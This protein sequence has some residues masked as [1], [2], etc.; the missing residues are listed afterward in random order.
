MWSVQLIKREEELSM[1]EILY[2]LSCYPSKAKVSVYRM[3]CA[4]VH[5][6]SKDN[7]MKN[8]FFGTVWQKFQ[9]NKNYLKLQEFWGFFLVGWLVLVWF[10]FC[11][12]V[13]VLWFCFCLFVIFFPWLQYT[14]PCYPVLTSGLFSHAQKVQIVT[15][16]GTK[17]T[18]NLWAAELPWWMSEHRQLHLCN[19]CFHRFWVDGAALQKST[20]NFSSVISRC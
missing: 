16:P 14:I 1:L 5:L 20:A 9:G 12:G 15:Q 6:S 3:K 18:L 10:A 17:E 13:C 19:T 11:A 7:K 8:P 4:A 2:L